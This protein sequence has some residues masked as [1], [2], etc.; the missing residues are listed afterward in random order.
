M[1]L[2]PARWQWNCFSIPPYTDDGRAGAIPNAATPLSPENCAGSKNTTAPGSD[3]AWRRPP[4]ARR[5]SAAS[6]P[7]NDGTAACRANHDADLA[8]AIWHDGLRSKWPLVVRSV[9]GGCV[10]FAHCAQEITE[11]RR[12]IQLEPGPGGSC[13]AGGGFKPPLTGR[14]TI[15]PQA[16]QDWNKRTPSESATTFSNLNGPACFAGSLVLLSQRLI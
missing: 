4:H 12:R 9:G 1:T 8:P 15:C 3:L 11:S 16:V 13:F 10:A 6:H 7:L 5:T 2:W 14:T